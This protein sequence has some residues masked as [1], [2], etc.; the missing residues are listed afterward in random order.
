[1]Q[2]RSIGQRWRA[3]SVVWTFQ[4][5]C[6]FVLFAV[7][8]IAPFLQ[9]D[10]NLTHT[11]IGLFISAIYTGT[12]ALSIPLGSLTDF[13]GVRRMLLLGAVFM[14]LLIIITSRAGTFIEIF[15]F[16]FLLGA[17]YSVI[18]PSTSKGII[19]WFPLN[20]RAMA[21]GV[22]QSGV[23]AGG[24][25]AAAVLPYLASTLGWPTGLI[26][27]GIVAVIFGA[28]LWPLYKE[29]HAT[30][31]ETS[32]SHSKNLREL[33]WNK[34]IL[35]ICFVAMVYGAVQLSFVTYLVLYL[36]EVIS[37]GV[38]L[39][40][41][42]LAAA[43]GAGTIA[44]IVFGLI[45]DRLFHGERKITL[46]IIGCITAA[47]CLILGYMTSDTYAWAIFIIIVIFG[48][49]S[50]GHNALMITFVGES[51]RKE[52]SGT[53]VG[54]LLTIISIGVII[55]PPLFGYIVDLKETYSLAWQSL[56]VCMAIAIALLTFFVKETKLIDLRKEPS[57]RP[58]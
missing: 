29:T 33:L 44:R 16:L 56:A 12:A 6:A 3:L 37:L 49:S 31:N 28:S 20:E 18:P 24:L 58:E 23:T 50:M 9:A 53:A 2:S 41:F 26:L 42:Y 5:I 38:V 14:G 54:L 52:L 21:M 51:A 22:K 57:A 40:G 27:S 47:M 35:I 39:A 43:N 4:T 10:L 30:R 45:S 46:I 13:F 19:E 25:I 17:A 7:P 36:E 32:F 48:F 34:D 11:Q 55:G 8:P 1:M 15:I